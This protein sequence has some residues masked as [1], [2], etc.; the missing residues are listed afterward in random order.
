M[1]EKISMRES[2][3][4]TCA[5]FQG[6]K[7]I[8]FG[9]NQTGKRIFINGVPDLAQISEET[10]N[11]FASVLFEGLKNNRNKNCLNTSNLLTF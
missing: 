10:L 9:E 2:K 7:E 8:P 1:E 4:K 11:C 6:I 3:A 5:E